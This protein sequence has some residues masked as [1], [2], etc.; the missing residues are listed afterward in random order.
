MWPLARP[1]PSAASREKNLPYSI[2]HGAE[3]KFV[4]PNMTNVIKKEKKQ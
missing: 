2:A 3:R 1:R 4:I